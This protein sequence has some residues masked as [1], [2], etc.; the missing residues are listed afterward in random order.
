MKINQDT[1]QE[2]WKFE[3]TGWEKTKAVRYYHDYFGKLTSQVS[4]PLLDA[5][6]VK[7]RTKMLDVATGPG[8]TAYAAYNRGADVIGIDF[9]SSMI[10][11]AH[12]NYPE[13]SFQVA[14]AESLPYEKNTFGAVVINF[15]ILHL[16]RP[17]KALSEAYRVLKPSGKI[18]FTVWANPQQAI[19]FN[20]ILNAIQK[21]G[22]MNVA[23]PPAPL[24]FRFSNPDESKKALIAA[25][26]HNPE[27][28]TVPQIWQLKKP[29][30]VFTAFYEGAVRT[31]GI[32]RAQSKQALEKIRKTIGEEATKYKTKNGIE[33]PMPAVLSSAEK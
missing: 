27:V 9:S 14:D 21:F 5:T 13:I 15:G 24:F 26:F 28:I 17:E 8:Y 32:L 3:H 19:G 33:I 18:G 11:K 16:A 30:E 2:F 23:I 31:G 12:A 29:D 10:K 25:G 4:E 7:K 20:I 6:A 1:S 22:T